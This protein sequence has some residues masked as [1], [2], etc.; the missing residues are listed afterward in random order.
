MDYEEAKCPDE[1]ENEFYFESD[2]LA[3][4][5]NKDYSAF[6][7]TIVILEAQRTRAIEDLDKLMSAR[8]R[9]MKDPISFVAQLQNGDFPELP[10]LQKIAELPYIDW[11]QYNIAVP[12]IR[13]P[14]TR[15]G[16]LL[17]QVQSKAEQESGKVLV[18][19]RAFD[20]SKPETFN[21]LWTMEEQRRLE[22][23][24]KEY[25]PEEV[26]MR[27]WTKIA[28]AL[29]NRTPKQVSSRVQKYFIKLLRAG[30]P[31]PGKG[32]KLKLD[33]K[34]GL[35][36]RHRNNHLLFKRSTFFPHQDI[37]CNMSE[38]IKE[39]SVADELVDNTTSR[40]SDDNPELRQIS[41][42]RQV[43]AEKEQDSSSMY[44]HVGYKCAGCGEDPLK[45][46]RWHCAE[47]YSGIDLC[48]DCAVTQFE[49]E[50]PVHDPSHRLIPMKPP[51]CTRSY[52]VDYFPQSFSASS[53]N[54]LDPNFLPE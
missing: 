5:G 37:S 26:E 19:G 21:Q 11:S 41:L 6:L 44:K 1:E 9:A 30:L 43:K 53:Y 54:Y 23:L 46:T 20:D 45:G 15:H 3:L 25:P 18:R 27:R 33:A 14:Q 49:S 38:E 7:K 17:P 42:L 39:Q 36:H 51:Q 24:L 52:D 40:G 32:P 50:K 13:R 10:G 22:E 31:I 47:C 4:K 2:H 12:D 29:G 35:T 34:K 48:G 8:A 16:H 28:N